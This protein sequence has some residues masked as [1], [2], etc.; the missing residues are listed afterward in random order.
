MVIR[1][2][3]DEAVARAAPLIVLHSVDPE[4]PSAVLSDPGLAPAAVTGEDGRRANALVA[5]ERLAELV[6]QLPV[7]VES[8]VLEESPTVAIPRA[9]V[10]MGA[11]LVVLGAPHHSVLERLVRGGDIVVELVHDCTCSVLVAREPASSDAPKL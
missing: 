8:I 11:D 1:L 10:N 9:A 2:G 4:M 3:H 6:A 5:R 7:P